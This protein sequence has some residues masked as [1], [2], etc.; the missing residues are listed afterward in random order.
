[1][2]TICVFLSPPVVRKFYSLTGGDFV[3]AKEVTV[4]KGGK[5]YAVPFGEIVCFEKNL[6]KIRLH[7]AGQH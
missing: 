4:K 1:M 3:M 6:R 7:T 5:L 2:I